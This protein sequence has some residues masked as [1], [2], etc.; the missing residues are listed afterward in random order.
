M[1]A[2]TCGHF[3]YMP[4]ALISPTYIPGRDELLPLMAI[5]PQQVRKIRIKVSMY[6]LSIRGRE[7]FDASARKDCYDADP[8]LTQVK[9]Y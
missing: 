6:F 5:S 9:F 1:N 7:Q 3:L 8:G 2:R 4:A